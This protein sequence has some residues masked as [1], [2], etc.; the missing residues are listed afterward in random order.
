MNADEET[1]IEQQA[2][3]YYELVF[4]DETRALLDKAE[5][6][7]EDACERLQEMPCAVTKYAT[8]HQEETTEW[9]IELAAGGPAAR[10]VV[11]ANEYGEVSEARFEFQDWFTPWTP[12]ANQDGDMVRRFAQMVGYYDE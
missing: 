5:G 1:T 7:D 9:H 2:Q 10:L 8:Y 6:G 4:D 3:E 11:M 12:A